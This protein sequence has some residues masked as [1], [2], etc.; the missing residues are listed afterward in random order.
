MR[1]TGVI[2]TSDE[3]VYKDTTRRLTET[4]KLFDSGTVSCTVGTGGNAVTT[5]VYTLPS[6]YYSL[7]PLAVE[8]TI[9]GTVASGETVTITVKA[10]LDDGSTYTIASLSKTGA[11][12][13]AMES[14]PLANLLANL[15]TA[16]AEGRRIVKIEADASSSATSTSA[17]ATVR[18]IGVKT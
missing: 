3:V 11:T 16:N 18:A 5:T 14:A 15:G 1:K 2:L 17:T 7:I 4:S 8:M 9:G 6:D 13:S 10:V 12:G